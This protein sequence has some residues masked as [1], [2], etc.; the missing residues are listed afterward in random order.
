MSEEKK[1]FK[2]ELNPSPSAIASIERKRIELI[3]KLVASG[4]ITPEEGVERIKSGDPDDISVE[5]CFNLS[6]EDL[7]GVSTG[8]A[9]FASSQEVSGSRPELTQPF[10]MEEIFEPG[11]VPAI[12]SANLEPDFVEEASSPRIRSR[13]RSANNKIEAYLI[14]MEARDSSIFYPG[15]QNDEGFMVQASQL[16]A[17]E[18][19]LPTPEVRSAIVTYLESR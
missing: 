4:K 5:A 13:I 6:P 19:G 16:V 3:Q 18:L 11:D 12:R 9:K 10:K 17:S 15:C 14:D 8:Y 2:E 7:G 1:N